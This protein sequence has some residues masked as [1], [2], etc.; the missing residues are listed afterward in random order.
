VFHIAE[1]APHVGFGFDQKGKGEERRGRGFPPSRSHLVYLLDGR[2]GKKGERRGKSSWASVVKPYFV[3]R[4]DPLYCALRSVAISSNPL[5]GGTVGR[6]RKKGRKG[7]RGRKK[8]GR[9][10]PSPSREGFLSTI[11]SSLIVFS[12]SPASGCPSPGRKKGRE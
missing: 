9:K 12:S 2:E 10:D 5:N 11:P 1:L 6:G 4:L 3:N 8:R 7:K